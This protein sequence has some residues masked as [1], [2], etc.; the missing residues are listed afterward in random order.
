MF[1]KT[2]L[3]ATVL[4]FS[5]PS[6]SAVE[7]GVY[8]FNN[9]FA[10]QD[11]SFKTENGMLWYGFKTY[12]T[13]TYLNPVNR[14][15]GM[16]EMFKENGMGI[17]NS[18]GTYAVFQSIEDDT[19]V[20]DSASFL[21][22]WNDGM[23]VSVEGWKGNTL[24]YTTNLIVDSDEIQNVNF[25]YEGINRVVFSSWGGIPNELYNG[26]SGAF[27]AVD[28]ISVSAV[29]EPSTYAMLGLGLLAVGAVAR[30]KFY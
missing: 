14:P 25:N 24:L 19:F 23:T 28:N 16:S 30:K 3:A 29:P 21:G 13:T 22:V 5:V 12:D 1:K 11:L 27:F 7:Y 17:Y 9:A 4:T 8:D 20:F 15:N 10:D 6:L 26:G 18:G 2:L